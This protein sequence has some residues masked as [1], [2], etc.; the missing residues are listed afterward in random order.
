MQ[1][2]K[3]QARSP[4]F[5]HFS[6]LFEDPAWSSSK[7]LKAVPSR[8]FRAVFPKEAKRQ[9]NC[10]KNTINYVPSATADASFYQYIQFFR[11]RFALLKKQS[12]FFTRPILFKS[13]LFSPS[14]PLFPDC[15]YLSP[16]LATV[17][18]STEYRALSRYKTVALF[19]GA[20]LRP[21]L[22]PL[23][24]SSQN[25]GAKGSPHLSVRGDSASRILFCAA[26][27]AFLR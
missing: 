24:S 15:S 16:L 18:I 6:D 10:N 20:P 17:S 23:S 14:S 11:L 13:P 9:L 1:K 7:G 8:G 19:P 12:L 3:K 4:G 27:Q 2:R 21:S 26:L 22:F 5:G 25:I